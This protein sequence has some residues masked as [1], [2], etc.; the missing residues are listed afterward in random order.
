MSY[1]SSSSAAAEITYNGCVQSRFQSTLDFGEVDGHIFVSR[2]TSIHVFSRLSHVC[3]RRSV[4]DW[5][6]DCRSGTTATNITRISIIIIIISRPATLQSNT[7]KHVKY[8][9]LHS[10]VGGTLDFG[11]RTDPVLPSACSRWVTT[12]WVNRLLRVSQLS[13]SSFRGR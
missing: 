12:M 3:G 10:T 6:V 7:T 4:S 9:W 1:I 11:R 2:Q 5:T 8:G 13:L